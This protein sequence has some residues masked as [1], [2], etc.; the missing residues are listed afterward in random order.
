MRET[1]RWIGYSLL[2]IIVTVAS[3][4]AAYRIRGPSHAQREALALM[5][6]DYR[7][8]AGTNAFPLL[9]YVEYD[10]ADAEV[11]PRFAEELAAFRASLDAD[12]VP[13]PYEPH[14]SKLAETSGDPKRLCDLGGGGCVAKAMA[15]PAVMRATLATYPVIRARDTAFKAADYYWNEFPLD[16]RSV[17]AAVPLVAQRV[18]LSAY[19]LEYADGDHIAALADTC[20]N[21]DAWRRMHRGTNS[22]IGSML[23]IASTDGAMRLFADMLAALPA[24]ESVPDSCVHAL[25]PIEAA[26]VDRCAEMAGEFG[27]S[28]STL[29]Y[30]AGNATRDASWADRVAS[31]ITFDPTQWRAWLAEQDAR[32]CD[33]PPVSM[34]ADTPHLP[35]TFRVTERLEC[36]AGV[37]GCMLAEI[38]APVYVEYDAR[39]LDFAARLRLTAALLWLRE[40]TRAKPLAQ[41]FAERP[42]TLR[43]GTRNS[44]YDSA[45]G[46]LFVDN[47][48]AGRGPRFE[49]PVASARAG[50]SR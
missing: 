21:L 23:A 34:L 33:E 40:T 25:R 18:W 13:I 3:V 35:P 49:L 7:P 5:Q 4:F 1:F 27:Y 37:Y 14:A 12:K 36:V 6:K 2:A 20:G 19:A 11:V 28:A 22:L 43:S 8:K 10:V 38:A 29:D 24:G 17:I 42:D 39:T 47:I 50:G 15:D 48:W 32:Y 26:D 31:W 9:W 45:S 44:G 46:M 16:S 30:L 41:R